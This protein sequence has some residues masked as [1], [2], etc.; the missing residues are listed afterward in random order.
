M[1]HYRRQ[2]NEVERIK[3]R[4]PIG[5]RLELI[6]MDDPYISVESGTRGTVQY[7]D[8]AGTIHINWDNG[9]SLG[10][11]PGEDSFRKLTESELNDETND[12]LLSEDNL[13]ISI[14]LWLWGDK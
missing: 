14:K 13:K 3:K 1:N 12:K 2:K 5:V 4:Y 9:R 10:I 7:V 11:V 8:D 6:N